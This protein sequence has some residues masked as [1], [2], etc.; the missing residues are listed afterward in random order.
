MATTSTTPPNRIE[1]P[2]FT[3]KQ[4]EIWDYLCESEDG[5]ITV[6]G[7]GGSYGGGKSGGLVRIAITLMG[8]YPGI[9][10]LIAR[11]T[12][13]NLKTPGG[14]IDQFLAALP[15][16]AV[17]VKQ[18]GV[19]SSNLTENRAKLGIRLPTWPDGVESKVYFRGTD[20]DTFFKSAEIGAFLLEEADGTNEHTWTYGISRLRQR[21]PDGTLPKYF[22]LAVANPSVSWFK[23]WFI[24][25]LEER[26]KDFE[27]AGRVK[28][29]LSKQSD[30][31]YLPENYEN[32]LRATLDDEEIA[33]NVDGSFTS[34][35]GRVYT[36]FSPEIHGVHQQDRQRGA[37][38]VH[39]LTS[40]SPAATKSMVIH[41]ERLV[42]PK[43]RY[44]VGG[45]DFGGAQRNAHYST[46]AVA[47][48]TNSGRDYLVDTFFSNGPGV[49]L[50]QVE[51]MREMERAFGMQIDWAA[52]GTQPTF[53]SLMQDQG[54]HIMRNNGTNDAWSQDVDYNRTRFMVQ[55]DGFPMSMYLDTSRNREWVKQM[56][57]YRL[58]MKAG[59]NGVMRN[60]PV[61]KD[62]D[63]YDA[64]RYMKER[65]QAI[66]RQMS[67]DK[68][69]KLPNHEQ[70]KMGKADPLS[71]FDKFIIENK[72]RITRERAAELVR[73]ARQKIG[74]PA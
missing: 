9:R 34:F 16:G 66:Q 27:G 30:N 58:E 46:G 37:E 2:T 18:G 51:W 12:L 28:F 6:A 73:V 53:I 11:N 35:R 49:H 36:N 38:T 15:A 26:Q 22:A 64:Y 67:P 44:A 17:S 52:D 54:F 63:L 39:G 69:A 13:Q 24:D 10:I 50:R 25:N 33:A 7:W 23:D 59:P 3:L 71:E 57:Q 61:R 43:F 60:V 55:D 48:V 41:G 56:Q 31:P 74:A 45:L 8:M 47:V 20:D 29:F 62:D 14:T 42:V 65:L 40:W 5:Q 68:Q 4:A 70:P 32:I 1:F 19:V 72:E 21:L